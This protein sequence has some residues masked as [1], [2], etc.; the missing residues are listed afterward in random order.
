MVTLKYGTERHE[1]QSTL[2]AVSRCRGIDDR[3]LTCS[4]VGVNLNVRLF[5]SVRRMPRR[6][7]LGVVHKSILHATLE[8]IKIIPT[9]QMP[10]NT[11][12]SRQCGCHGHPGIPVFHADRK[13]GVKYF[14][15]LDV[16]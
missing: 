2:G 12:F 5:D 4:F 10:Q 13:V 16:V 15:N 3:H 9:P 7:K 6:E 8:S 11:R 14:V 1:L